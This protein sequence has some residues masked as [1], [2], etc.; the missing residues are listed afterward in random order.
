ME[1]KEEYYIEDDFT[2]EMFQETCNK[3][4]K[5]KIF[6]YPNWKTMIN[7][8]IKRVKGIFAV[9][10][11]VVKINNDLYKLN[12][13]LNQIVK[14]N[15]EFKGII[16]GLIRAN[17]SRDKKI[18]NLQSRVYGNETEKHNKYTEAVRTLY[19]I[20]VKLDSFAL[21]LAQSNSGF[22]KLHEDIAKCIVGDV[23]TQ[24]IRTEV[25]S[26]DFKGEINDLL[27]DI[28][29]FNENERQIISD[30]L[31]KKGFGDI[32]RYLYIPNPKQFDNKK[33][34]AWYSDEL[35]EGQVYSYVITPY[36]S[37]PDFPDQG[38]QEVRKARV[39][40]KVKSSKK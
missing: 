8:I 3:K 16:S 4:V 12:E 13:Q 18:E 37:M 20:L 7:C 26:H 25:N 22:C 2:I 33:C 36:I 39:S 38:Q 40:N 23:T 9:K 1:E 6:I 34:D 21:T 17:E 30:Y 24:S 11:D 14:Q 35:K 32:K 31:Q 10:E 5:G 28:D 29:R 15:N 19:G 27:D